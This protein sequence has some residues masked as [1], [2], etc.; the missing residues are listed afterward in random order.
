MD[1]FCFLPLSLSPLFSGEMKV[2]YYVLV[3]QGGS[4]VKIPLKE[5]SY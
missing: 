2:C 5:D 1:S 3:G 4:Q